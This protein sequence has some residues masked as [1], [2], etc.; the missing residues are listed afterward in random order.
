MGEGERAPCLQFCPR[1]QSHH[2]P[3]LTEETPGNV[4]SLKGTDQN[5]FP[6]QAKLS[7]V[8]SQLNP[9]DNYVLHEY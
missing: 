5:C 8:T 9:S 6:F 4:P 7:W 3:E 1:Q 2:R